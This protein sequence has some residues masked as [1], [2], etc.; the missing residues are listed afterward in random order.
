VKAVSSEVQVPPL[1][2][3]RHNAALRLLYKSSFGPQSNLSLR[4]CSSCS[5]LWLRN[6]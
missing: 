3:Q 4:P 2:R 5:S 6:Q 1:L